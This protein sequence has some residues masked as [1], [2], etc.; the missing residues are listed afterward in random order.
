ML[1]HFWVLLHSRSFEIHRSM[2]N[3]LRTHIISNVML[4][5]PDHASSSSS[6]ISFLASFTWQTEFKNCVRWI[7]VSWQEY[8][9]WSVTDLFS[10]FEWVT[11][12]EGTMFDWQ[13]CTYR[14][15]LW[16]Y[17]YLFWRSKIMKVQW[18]KY[19]H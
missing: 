17:V 12:K 9:L 5:S 18:D 10:F 7:G 1:L 4:L 8:Y 3:I 11:T 16:M 19:F 15:F 6:Y 13:N 2:N 14:T